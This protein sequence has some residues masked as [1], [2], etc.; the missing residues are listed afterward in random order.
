MTVYDVAKVLQV[1]FN[2]VYELVRE[3]KIKH[4]KIGRNIRI[5]KQYLN[6]F[7]QKGGENI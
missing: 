6:E 5:P 1:H 3:N 4:M 7:I 2:T